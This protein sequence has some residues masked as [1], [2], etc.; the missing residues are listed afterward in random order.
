MENTTNNNLIGNITTI[1]K[2]IAMMIAGW[3]IRYCV[4]KGIQLPVDQE[5]LSE[6]IFAILL[7]I[8]GYFDAKY[9]NTYFKKQTTTIQ[10]EETVL[11]PEYETNNGDTDGNT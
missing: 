2:L 6:I 1:G 5:T 7:L 11:N 9:Q 4:S 8:W 3:F 10:T